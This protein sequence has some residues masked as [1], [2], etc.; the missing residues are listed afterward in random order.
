MNKFEE[1]ASNLIKDIKDSKFVQ[2][3]PSERELAKIYNT[4]PVTAAKALNF[5]ESKHIVVRKRGN[6]TFIN[7]NRDEKITVRISLPDELIT[8]EIKKRISARFPEIS[9]VYTAP[10]WESTDCFVKND[11][12]WHKSSIMPA[13]YD[14]LCRPL[15]LS[16]IS[17]KIKSGMYNSDAFNINRSN[18]HY[19]GVPLFFSPILLIYNKT[20]FRKLDLPVPERALK[21]SEIHS[22]KDSIKSSADIN[23]FAVSVSAFS[24]IMNCIF[25]SMNSGS[26][27]DNISWPEIEKGLKTCEEFHRTAIDKKIDFLDGKSLFTYQCRQTLLDFKNKISFDWD[28][29]PVFYGSRRVCTVGAESCFISANSLLRDDIIIPVIDFLLS[30]EIQDYIASKSFG[31]PVLKSSALDSLSEYPYRDDYFF[32]ECRNI[33]YENSLFEKDILRIFSLYAN[34]Y[35]G[36]LD[37]FKNFLTDVE[38]LFNFNSLRKNN[39]TFNITQM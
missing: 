7:E 11:I 27:L 9:F 22:I 31:I 37:T 19:Y 6:G 5:L 33:A 24:P 17:D 29:L 34:K 15:P 39:S 38:K 2:K 32:S 30:Q 28:V 21:L 14:K 8:E 25:A 10:V 36:G 12:I 3:L 26:T 35:M 16:Y 20:L 18:L 23:L 4:T 13:S 1:I